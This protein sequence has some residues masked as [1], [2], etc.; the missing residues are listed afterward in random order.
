MD[1]LLIL[2]SLRNLFR[3]PLRAILFGAAGFL[4][5]TGAA[6]AHRAGK[7][8][9]AWVDA[10]SVCL[11]RLGATRMP[12]DDNEL[13]AALIRGWEKTITFPDQARVVT[14]QGGRF[15]SV[16]VLRIDLSRGTLHPS[17]KKDQI[18]VN[19]K[20]E[21]SLKVSRLEVKAQPLL[22]EKAKLNMNLTATDARLAMER[23][24][25]GRP[26]MML[27][28]AKAGTLLFDCTRADLE[29]L[30]LQS[31]REM[32]SKYG[33]DVDQTKLTFEQESPRSIQA[34]L[35]L[36]TRF[37][38][39]PAGMLFKAHVFVDDAM[40]ARISGL[41][42]DGDDI[43][44]PIIVGLLRPHLAGYNGRTRP[45]LS[46]PAGNLRLRDVG[47]KVDDSLHLTASFGH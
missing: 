13:S 47:L 34:S 3:R 18:R 23:D 36:H 45:L 27:T 43:L 11:F 46:F 6:P 12:R 25:K 14:M 31:A 33:V 17:G 28:D 20:V 44:G 38:F 15:P 26:V 35:Y 29:H 7:P 41:T 4:A 21:T 2:N 42:C 40:N 1:Q 39:V 32:G 16:D 24:R 37:A 22:L 5:L 10:K 19:N 8:G 30:F 9:S